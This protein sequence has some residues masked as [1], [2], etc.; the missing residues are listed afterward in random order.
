MFLYGSPVYVY[1]EGEVSSSLEYLLPPETCATWLIRQVP[2]DQRT[3][4]HCWQYDLSHPKI[5]HLQLLRG[6]V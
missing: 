1:Y 3:A 6:P 2:I 5:P 4:S